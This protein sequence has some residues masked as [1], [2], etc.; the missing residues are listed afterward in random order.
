MAR[1]PYVPI[2]VLPMILPGVPLKLRFAAV[3]SITA[4]CVVWV[5]LASWLAVVNL[6]WRTDV[7]IDSAA[8]LNWIL[9]HPARAMWVL[10]RSIWLQTE[11]LVAEFVGCCLGWADTALPASYVR[12]AEW[13]LPVAA[14]ISIGRL[15]Y[16]T[17]IQRQLGSTITILIVLAAV[18]ISIGLI[19]LVQ[20][21]TWT[22]VGADSVDGVQGRYFLP[23][24]L[25]GAAIL[26]DARLPWRMIPARYILVFVIAGFPVISLGV[27]MRAIVLRYYL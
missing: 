10:V 27:M 19:F 12:V 18:L 17:K 13:L 22:A 20:Y 26:C 25:L 2:A 24:A 4:A 8:Q 14:M 5:I 9:E 3:A 16:G 7:L 6:K 1:P 21:V 15:T 23:L 11:R